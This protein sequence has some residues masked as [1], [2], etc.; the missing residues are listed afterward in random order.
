MYGAFAGD[1]RLSS[2][3]PVINAKIVASLFARTA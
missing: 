2:I 3:G 1:G